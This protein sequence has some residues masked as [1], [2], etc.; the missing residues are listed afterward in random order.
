M[1]K[2]ISNVVKKKV[3]VIML[4]IIII[5]LSVYLFYTIL[6]QKDED[7]DQSS[8]YH[9]YPIEIPI[10]LTFSGEKVPLDDP[11]IYERFE[12]ELL[13]NT[14]W[15]ASTILLMKRTNRWL[16]AIDTILEQRHIPYDFRYLCVIES[17][18]KNVVSPRGATG[19]WQFLTSTGREFG[20]EINQEVDERYDPIKSTY[21]ACKYFNKA[22]KIFGNWTDVAAS[23]NMG[24]YGIKKKYKEQKVLS[25][26]DLQ[27]N[28]ETSRYLFRIL[29]LKE[30]LEHPLRYGYNISEK[31]LYDP[32]K[33]REVIVDS[34][35]NDLVDFAIDQGINLK[36]LKRYNPWLI[37]NTLTIKNPKKTYKIL[38]P[39]NPPK[40]NIFY[41]YIFIDTTAADTFPGYEPTIPFLPGMEP[42]TLIKSENIKYEDVHH[43][44]KEGE[45]LKMIA[46]KYA[47]TEAEIIVWNKLIN[48]KIETGQNL[49][50]HVLHPVDIN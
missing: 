26:Y 35:I 13:I 47:L 25:Y 32:F 10:E 44:V 31:H 41:R 11:D 8:R 42:D 29:A 9:F 50:I 23:Y 17:M 5:F 33:N 34:T 7:I 48:G 43:I 27:L 14:Y 3:Q 16:P 40:F 21:A 30:L 6:T 46:Q 22:H 19:F 45:T 1:K 36:I 49:V 37:G 24:M 39:I 38:I 20:L 15:S 28:M 12:R 18:L 2:Q 4:C